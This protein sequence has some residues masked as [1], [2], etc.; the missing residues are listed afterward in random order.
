MNIGITGHQSI[1]KEAL[2]YVDAG[3]KKL[4]ASLPEEP[5]GVSCLAAGA[6]QLFARALLQRGGRLQVIIP[7]ADYESTFDDPSDLEAYR[8]LLRRADAVEQLQYV[9]PSEEAFLAAGKRVAEL[10][11]MLVAVWD[12][13][14]SKGKG[15][16]ADIVDYAR[17]HGKEVIV[18]WPA[19]VTR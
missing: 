11:Q 10:S 13:R 4:L 2:S 16:T 6:D 14:G 8:D 1:P 19:Y 15:G 5:T 9:A 17:D 3:I 12:G 18:V 7:S